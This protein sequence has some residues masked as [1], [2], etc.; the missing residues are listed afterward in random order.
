MGLDAWG[1]AEGLLT[2][3]GATWIESAKAYNFALYSTDATAVSL[4][5]YGDNDF[6]NPIKTFAFD[7]PA[8][9][10]ARIWHMLVPAA[11]IAGAKYYAYKVDGPSVPALVNASTA[12]KSFLTHTP[13]AFFFHRLSAERLRAHPAP[14]TAR[15]RSGSC[16]P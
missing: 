4:L 3:L 9:K 15:H 13:A 5:F 6:I 16:L 12:A 1:R 11:E 10:T 2:P 14:T 8:H 7:F